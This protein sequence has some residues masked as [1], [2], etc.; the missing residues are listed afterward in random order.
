MLIAA[1]A[2]RG[3]GW[4]RGWFPLLKMHDAALKPQMIQ[5]LG[6]GEVFMLITVLSSFLELTLKM[7]NLLRAQTSHFTPF[8]FL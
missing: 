8:N 7:S 3:Q 2:Q 5:S 4:A 1:G 6:I